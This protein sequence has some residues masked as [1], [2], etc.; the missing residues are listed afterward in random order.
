MSHATSCR[1]IEG[2][3]AVRLC[4]TIALAACST[5]DPPAELPGAGSGAAGGTVHAF[6]YLEDEVDRLLAFL[7][8]EGPFPEALL[9]DSVVLRLAPEGGGD[10]AAFAREEL[11]SPDAWRIEHHSLQPPQ[12]YRHRT[13]TPGLHTNCR[14]VELESRFP[15]LARFPHVGVRLARSEAAD[16]LQTWNVTFVFDEDARAPRLTAVVYD[17]WEW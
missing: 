13:I 15:E 11:G 3:V 8:G 6:A 7:Q 10:A 1:R 5:G 9:A 12:G 4:A 14:A 16:C 2:S 17:Q